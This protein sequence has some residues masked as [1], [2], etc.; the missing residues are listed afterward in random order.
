MLRSRLLSPL[1]P[2]CGLGLMLCLLAASPLH[3][4]PG[5]ADGM[6]FP[7]QALEWYL[8]GEGGLV[9]EH[10]G[11]MMRALAES[12]AGMSEA[13]REITEMMG[14]ITGVLG[15]QMFPHPEDAGWQVYVRTARHAEVPEMNWIVIFRPRDSEIQMIMPQPR[16]TIQVLFPEV[17]LP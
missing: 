13:G 16:Q 1:A 12:P 6:A 11:E 3:A 8:S 10:A 9:W 5:S 7:R 2:S 14:P 15:E 4:Q 17:R